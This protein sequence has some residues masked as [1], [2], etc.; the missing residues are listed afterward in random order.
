MAKF[1]ITTPIFYVNDRAHI[2]H[3]YTM[4]IA[5]TL[6]RW[7]RLKGDDVLFL[8]G[9]DEHGEKMVKAAAASGKEPQQFVDE[10]R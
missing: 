8:T 10:L 2:G 5:D 9:T 4:V 6:A 7:H 1:Y 3:F